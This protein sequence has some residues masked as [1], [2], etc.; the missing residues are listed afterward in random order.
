MHDE[1]AAAVLERDVVYQ[2]REPSTL[3]ASSDAPAG[4]KTCGR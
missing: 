4:I 3:K 1:G 2:A